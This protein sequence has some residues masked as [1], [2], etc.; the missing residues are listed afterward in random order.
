MAIAKAYEVQA[1]KVTDW[2]IESVFNEREIAIEEAKCLLEH[3]RI[4]GVRVV[5]EKFDPRSNTVIS[6]IVFR[7]SP[8]EQ[9]MMGSPT[10]PSAPPPAEPVVAA[11]ARQPKKP[12]GA[13]EQLAIRLILISSAGIAILIGLANLAD[14]LR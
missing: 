9:R 12:K 13:L 11:K 8:P 5:E 14:H 1:C 10:R 7:G 3:K 2:T 4:K 6:L